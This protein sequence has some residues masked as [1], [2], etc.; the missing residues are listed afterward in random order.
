MCTELIFILDRSGSMCG[1]EKDTIGGFNSMIERQQE[2][3]GDAFI[4]TVLFDNE[5]ELLHDRIKLTHMKAITD[6]EYFVRGSTA[7]LDAI[8]RTIHKI[9]NVQ[10]N[11][12]KNGQAKKVMFVITT[13]G[14]ENASVE[15]SYGKIR[16]L[17]ETQKEQYQ[18]EFIFLGANIDAIQTA[19]Q[20]GIDEDR[21]ANYNADG[22]GTVL[23]YD[24]I[25]E[26]VSSVRANKTLSSDWKKRIEVDFGSRRS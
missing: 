18:W 7:L 10:K 19:R 22:E 9:I 24:V 4:T 23:N 13:D 17:I 6:K 3:E 15:Y 1:L 21:A 11:T 2:Q 20:F 12:M 8:G 5:Y 26:A 25:N 14:M 16:E